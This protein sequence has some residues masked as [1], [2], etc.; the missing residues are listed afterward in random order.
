MAETQKLQTNILMDCWNSFRALP[1]WV[2]IWVMFFLMPINMASIL[3]ISEP[4]GLLIAFLANIAMML[5][6]PVMLYD[7]GFS[8][9]MAIPHIIPWTILVIVLIFYRPEASGMYDTYL[10]VLL[11]ANIIS[12]LFDYPDAWAWLSGNRS[13]AG[14]S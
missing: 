7:R 3:F 9:L 14:R 1:T 8:K 12:L 10:T 6:L 4:K 13:V 2:Q 5:N 11:G